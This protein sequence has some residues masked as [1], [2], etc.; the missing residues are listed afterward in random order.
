MHLAKAIE[1]VFGIVGSSS[2]IDLLQW[3]DNEHIGILRVSHRYEL[4][5]KPVQIAMYQYPAL[6]LLVTICYFVPC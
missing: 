3:D 1:S 2:H 5:V 6:I 4:V